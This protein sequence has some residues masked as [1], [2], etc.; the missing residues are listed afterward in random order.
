MALPC[1]KRDRNYCKDA[2]LSQKPEEVK[3]AEANG[4]SIL[5]QGDCFFYPVVKPGKGVV[6]FHRAIDDDLIADEMVISSSGNRLVR[7][8]VTH[9][10]HPTLRLTGWHKAVQNRAIRSGRFAQG[11]DAD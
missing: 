6:K 1:T 4:L 11:N 5:R 7:G 2:T 9:S 3:R 8:E 10:E